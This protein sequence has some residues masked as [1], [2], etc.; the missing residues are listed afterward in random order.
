MKK[1][2]LV[3]VAGVI[4]LCSCSSHSYSHRTVYSEKKDLIATPIVTELSVDFNKRIEAESGKRSTV[5]EARDEAYFKALSENKIDV[6]VD[7]IY[8]TTTSGK[9]LFFG[10]KTSAK[11]IGFAGKYTSSKQILDA[12]NQYKV[13]PALI[14]NFREL[15]LHTGNETK[16][17]K[18][19]EGRKK[20]GLLGLGILGIL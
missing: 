14:N 1:K 13:E 4:T 16:D 11:V 18:I 19:S 10:G 5:K 8:N 12:V 2:L 7:P 9:I 3:V 6:L 15:V 20:G 17:A